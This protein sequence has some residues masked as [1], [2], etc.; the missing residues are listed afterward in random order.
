M[1][2][3]ATLKA[4]KPT[5]I[6]FAVLTTVSLMTGF[7]VAAEETGGWRT[8]LERGDVKDGPFSKD[9]IGDRGGILGEFQGLF[10]NMEILS[11]LFVDFWVWI[12]HL[13]RNIAYY[14]VALLTKIY[15]LLLFVLQT[16]LF[17]FD[18]SYIKDANVVFAGTSV[19]TV[20]VLTMVEG[21]KRMFQ[22][23]HNN[24]K[25]ISKRWSLAVVGAGAA[26]FLFETIFRIINQVTSAITQIGAG[27]LRNSLSEELDPRWFDWVNTIAL[28]GFD[29]MLVAMVIPIFLQNGR[30]FFDL[31]CLAAI[32]PLALSAWVFDSHRHMFHKWWHNLKVMGETPLVYAIFIT[33]LGLFI[34][35]T[36]NIVSGGGLFIKLLVIVG[37]LS[38]MATPPS[39]VNARTDS[40]PTADQAL[41]NMFGGY[42]RAYDTV[43]LKNVRSAQ[44]IKEKVAVNKAN[45][46]KEIAK[47]R[48]E[49]GKRYV[50]DLLKK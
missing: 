49:T 42:K 47:L 43:T 40:G 8:L 15:E 32:T 41:W 13:P 34:F 39:F 45:K 27:E 4:L 5:L 10:K 1:V 44:F 3:E 21:I 36:R 30:R 50:K 31:M 37:G 17:I 2:C 46:A 25:D 22:K 6:P 7:D 35:G 12:N 11:Q 16:P 48:K 23:R 28:I 18:N 38:R 14:S 19:L 29:V 9:A 33:I 20:T 24:L 26:P